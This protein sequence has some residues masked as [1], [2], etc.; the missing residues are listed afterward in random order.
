MN[1]CNAHDFVIC[2]LFL[3]YTKAALIAPCSPCRF[4]VYF[5]HTTIFLCYILYSYLYYIMFSVSVLHAVFVINDNN[6]FSV[7]IIFAFLLQYSKF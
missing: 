1:H 4:S 6:T 5:V 7:L 2:R 3:L